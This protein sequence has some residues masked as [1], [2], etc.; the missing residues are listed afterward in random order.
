[1]TTLSNAQA[2]HA[3]APGIITTTAKGSTIVPSTAQPAASMGVAEL[4]QQLYGES[5]K[6]AFD[7][8][9]ANGTGYLNGAMHHRNL[10]LAI[11][12]VA[13]F[14]DDNVRQ[15]YVL[16]FGEAGNL[17]ILQ[18][19]TSD[20]DTYVRQIGCVTAKFRELMGDTAGLVRTHDVR[21]LANLHAEC[22]EKGLEFTQLY[23]PKPNTYET[24]DE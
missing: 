9:W 22:A 20:P 24:D 8:A 3:Q 15:V 1:M 10:P 4:L 19:Y 13:Q 17:V 5:R 23:V 7:P 16:G 2:M 14:V 6:V 11:G 18:R 21:V 12:E